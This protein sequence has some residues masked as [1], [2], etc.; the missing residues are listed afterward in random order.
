M[1]PLKTLLEQMDIT[2][3]SMM[4]ALHVKQCIDAFE[5]GKVGNA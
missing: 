4:V 2:V 3:H 5:N 1:K